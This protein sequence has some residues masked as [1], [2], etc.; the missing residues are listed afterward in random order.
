[1]LKALKQQITNIKREFNERAL[2]LQAEKLERSLILSEKIE[3]F[4]QIF[5]KLHSN[6]SD[7]ICIDERTEKVIQFDGKSFKVIQ[8]LQD[9]ALNTNFICSSIQFNSCLP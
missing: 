9:I 2:Q 5:K 3:K 1:M 6:D 4:Q 8:K 7:T